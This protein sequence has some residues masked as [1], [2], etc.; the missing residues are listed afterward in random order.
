MVEKEAVREK[1]AEVKLTNYEQSIQF[2]KDK[3]AKIK[4]EKKAI[5]FIKCRFCGLLS[6][7]IITLPK[8]EKL[9]SKS[10]RSKIKVSRPLN[11]MSPSRVCTKV[12]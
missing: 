2:Y 5:A 10:L 11:F 7:G 3:K 12:P 1:E 9:F 4:A 6:L 8:K